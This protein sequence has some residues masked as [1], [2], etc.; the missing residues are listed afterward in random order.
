MTRIS[1]SRSRK[2]V[3]KT[4][5]LS[6][7][8][9]LSALNRPKEVRKKRKKRKKPPSRAAPHFSRTRWVSEGCR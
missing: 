7:L 5:A 4:C 1:T 3:G 8:S 9:A 2:T 6:A